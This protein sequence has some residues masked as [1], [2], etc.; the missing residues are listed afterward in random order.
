MEV[1]SL[2]QY[3]DKDWPAPQKGHAAMITRMDGDIGKLMAKL[4]ELGIDDNTLVMFSSDNGPH[5]EGGGDPNFFK[6]AGP[7]RGYKRD[8]YEGG[9]R[10]PMLARWPGKIKTGSVSNHISAFWD[11]LP[12]CCELIGVEPPKDID[13][14][15]MLP[16]L[17]GQ[18]Q[19]QKKHEFLYWEFHEQGKKQAVRVGD[20]KGVRLDVAKD[21]NG[22]IE[23]YNLKDDIGEQKNLAMENTEVTEKIKGYL[24]AARTPSEH[25]PI[26]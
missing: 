12:T 8:L 21:P 25:W 22:L 14:I 4:K 1:P 6:S 10:V 23:L 9:I 17:L 3:A 5:K 26:P 2:G 15:S 16:T 24:K 11:F 20:W 19:R 18:P 13:G 7:L